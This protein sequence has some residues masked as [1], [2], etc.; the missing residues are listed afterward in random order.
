MKKKVIVGA[1]ASIV[2]SV[3]GLSAYFCSVK[4]DSI[5]DQNVEALAE[6]ESGAASCYGPKRQTF[7]FQIICKCENDVAC[8]DAHGCD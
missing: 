5:L 1:V 7:W 8:Q 6:Q 3:I 2:L 4:S